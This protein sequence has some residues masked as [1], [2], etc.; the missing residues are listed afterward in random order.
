ML[1]EN[2]VISTLGREWCEVL[3]DICEEVVPNDAYDVFSKVL[4]VDA[5]KKLL[6]DDI[7]DRYEEI[8]SRAN[9]FYETDCVTKEMI[10]SVVEELKWHWNQAE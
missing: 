9:D 7:S 3:P 2:N 4:G 10:K 8:A 1:D 6:L 5:V